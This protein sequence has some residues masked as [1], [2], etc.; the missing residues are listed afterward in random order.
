M[1]GVVLWSDR[2]SDR[3]LIWCEDHGKLAYYHADSSNEHGFI[4]EAGDLVRFQV[5]DTPQMRYA[6][7]PE[8]I[9]AEEYP[10]IANSLR[11]V[12]HPDIGPAP[13]MPAV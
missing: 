4:C 12:G 9:A 11:Q 7:Q 5:R 1:Y 3:A 13:T 6:E 10:L 2:N 8:I